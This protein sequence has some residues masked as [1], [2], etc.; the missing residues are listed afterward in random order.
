MKRMRALRLDRP[1]HFQQYIV[2][3]VWDG[4]VSG[5][6][7]ARGGDLETEGGGGKRRR[8]ANKARKK[9]GGGSGNHKGARNT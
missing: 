3:K 4:W 9:K 8:D 6:D 1:E 2:R 5:L 7:G